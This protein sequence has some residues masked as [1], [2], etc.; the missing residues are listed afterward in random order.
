MR[1]AYLIARTARRLT[2]KV[3]SNGAHTLG[4]QHNPDNNQIAASCHNDHAAKEYAPE[5]LTPPGHYEGERGNWRSAVLI[6]KH[7]PSI[8]DR[9]ARYTCRY[10]AEETEGRESEREGRK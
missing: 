3:V 4:G 1:D 6:D 5:H 2:Y 8:A 10:T 9:K 7:V